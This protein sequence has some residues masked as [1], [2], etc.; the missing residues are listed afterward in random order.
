VS[1]AV[2]RVP[3]FAKV[4]LGLEVLGPRQDGYHE[5]RTLFQTIDLH[6]D[7]VLRPRPHGVVVRCTHPA[8]PTDGSNLALRAAEALRR[9]A[10]VDRG[11]EITIEKRIPVAGGLGGGSSNAAAVLM[12]LDRL[13]RLDLGCDA[14]YP[15]AR[16]LGADV[17][18]F[19]VGGTA[20]GLARGDEVY[21]LRHQVSG[22]VV[23]VD[24]QRPVSTAAVFSRVAASL[25]PR[26]NSYTIFRFVSCDLGGSFPVGILTNEL[27]TA[28]LEEAPELRHQVTRIRAFLIR[29]G[30]L[31]ASLSGS[32]SSYFGLF[33]DAR[34]ARRAQAALRAAGFT[35]VRSRTLSLAQYRRSWSRSFAPGGKHAASR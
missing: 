19:L 30:A 26:E 34:R 23:V 28:A 21:P 7:I 8:V 3:S 33:D 25:T 4:N 11:V 18:Y 5:L 20:L 9:Y 27:E 6:D 35:A 24:T 32:G 22:H 10:R 16:R 17:P 29:D 2:L 13:W 12:A 1:R 31:L 15:L 14:L